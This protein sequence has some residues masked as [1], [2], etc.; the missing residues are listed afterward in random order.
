MHELVHILMASGRTPALH[1]FRAD[2][3]WMNRNTSSEVFCNQVAAATLMP[4]R[5]LLVQIGSADEP[6]IW[7]DEQLRQLSARY[8]VSREA[9]LLRLVSLGRADQA[10]YQ[11]KRKQ[12]EAEYR[13]RAEAQQSD[14]G[15]GDYYR[16]KVRD[17]GHRYIADV[18][19]AYDNDDISSRDVTQFL[20]VQLGQ[21]PRLENLVQRR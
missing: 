20:G 1:V 14:S 2:S 4:A 9:L 11:M 15:D 13:Q 16:L 10:F 5:D 18:L 3:S 19:A 21:L 6:G 12:F 7:T 17:L 8:N